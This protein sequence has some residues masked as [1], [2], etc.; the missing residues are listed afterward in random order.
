MN[1][2]IVERSILRRTNKERRKRGLR[3]LHGHTA[4]MRSA[5]RHSKWMASRS[6]F[7]HTGSGGSKPWDRAYAVGYPD[8]SVSENIWQSRGSKGGAWKSKFQWKSDW[9][10]GQAAVISWMNSPGHRQNLLNPKWNHIGIGVS[11][12]RK[13]RIYLVQNFGNATVLDARVL[14]PIWWLAGVAVLILL[15]FIRFLV[16]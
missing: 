1:S 6:I 15:A 9:Q 10:L 3:S 2:R 8:V 13:G 14:Q 11:K 16:V 7:S 12:N 5:R 4:L